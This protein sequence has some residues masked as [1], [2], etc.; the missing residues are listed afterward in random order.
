[1]YET[2]EEWCD[3]FTEFVRGMG[4]QGFIDQDS[5]IEDYETGADPRET[6]EIFVEEMTD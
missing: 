1:M 5:F 3:A 2:F 6:A 4:Y